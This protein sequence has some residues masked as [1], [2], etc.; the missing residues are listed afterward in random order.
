M[1]RTFTCRHEMDCTPEQFWERIHHNPQFNQELYVDLLGFG[2]ELIED[3]RETGARRSHIV[4]K[5]DAPK[6][7]IKALGDS[8]SFDEHGAVDRSGPA[9]VYRFN[10]IPGVWPD[11]IT[12]G[13]QM[14]VPEAPGGKCVRVVDFEVGCSVFGIGGLFERLVDEG[15]YSEEYAAKILQ[16]IAIA[17][18]HLHR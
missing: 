1:S 10:I 5:V 9:P 3:N 17:L 16:Q 14:T 12:V 11:K 18:Y 4:P 13:G 7:L 6:A 15:A 2:Y 8:V